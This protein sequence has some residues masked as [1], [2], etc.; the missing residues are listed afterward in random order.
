MELFDK[1]ILMLD[2]IHLKINLNFL[3]E[4]IGKIL[5]NLDKSEDGLHKFIKITKELFPSIL[6]EKCRYQYYYQNN[7]HLTCNTLIW[8]V[9]LNSP[10]K[11]DA[12]LES[13][14]QEIVSRN[15]LDITDISNVLYL[16]YS[17]QI[18]FS[19]DTFYEFVGRRWIEINKANLYNYLKYSFRYRLNNIENKTGLKVEEI[20]NRFES[21][22]FK[23]FLLSYLCQKLHVENF[24]N[25]NNLDEVMKRYR[26]KGS[27][28]VTMAKPEDYLIEPIQQDVPIELIG[29]GDDI[30][31]TLLNVYKKYPDVYKI[32]YPDAPIF[33]RLELDT[34]SADSKFKHILIRCSEKS[35]QW[36]DIANQW[37]VK[38]II[39]NKSYIIRNIRN[40]NTLEMDDKFIPFLLHNPSFV[41]YR[42]YHLARVKQFN[43]KSRRMCKHCF[44]LSLGEMVPKDIHLCK[45]C[46]DDNE[47]VLELFYQDCKKCGERKIH[48]NLNSDQCDSC[49]FGYNI[50]VGKGNSLSGSKFIYKDF[51][52]SCLESSSDEENMIS[53]MAMYKSFKG[54]LKDN[55]KF[56]KVPDRKTF[57]KEMLKILKYHH[58]NR[59]WTGIEFKSYVENTS[60]T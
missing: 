43:A 28:D 23:N 2:P 54:W 13:K 49:K 25:K 60:D 39:D 37:I 14:I 46:N 11:F 52:D 4:D 7:N 5:Y 16:C 12:L 59:K 58:E 34:K 26:E 55:H 47:S 18:I 22:S 50:D 27:L 42:N 10:D 33:L 36:T 32:A 48:S 1:L 3:W 9:K 24:R 45:K 21:E 8:Y 56:M 35:K 20:L 51:M 40:D 17:T 44:N 19:S 15:I 38:N 41:Q 29:D 53:E 30:D 57:V 6:I 31:I